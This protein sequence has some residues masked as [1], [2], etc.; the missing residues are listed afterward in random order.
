MPISAA[1]V[2][3]E[4]VVE[5]IVE[6]TRADQYVFRRAFRNHDATGINSNSL[7]FP[8]VDFDLEG[9][10]VE[11]PENTKYPRASLNHGEFKAAYT[12]YGFEVPVSDT[13]IE[14]SMLDVEADAGRQ[15]SEE[16]ERRL[17]EIAGAVIENNRDSTA[18]NA[19]GTSDGALEY[20]DFLEARK[21]FYAGGYSTSNLV[22]F[23]G[24]DEMTNLPNLSEFTPATEMGDR[25]IRSG[26]L[27][28]ESSL[29]AG[30]L[31]QIIDIPIWVSNVTN[32]TGGQAYVVDT[33][34]YGWESTR[35]PFSVKTYREE[36]M[37]QTVHKLRGRMDWISTDDLAAKKIDS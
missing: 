27:P 26:L 21:E 16:E 20:A 10:L 6:E 30:L 13:A 2:L 37:D 32:L 9:E 4:E 1:D 31:G 15:M 14:D 23:V 12:K 29:P 36:D 3:D 5:A 25:A 33:G 8:D 18:I 19:S 17:D 24:P 22:G 28:G 11:V 35:E 7:T 34:K